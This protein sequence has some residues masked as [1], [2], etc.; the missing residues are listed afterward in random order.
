MRVSLMHPLSLLFCTDTHNRNYLQFI[1]VTAI[2]FGLTAL[3]YLTAAV[4]V[5]QAAAE[6]EKDTKRL[7]PGL[8][9]EYEAKLEEGETMVNR[10][11]LLQELGNI[12]QP[13][14]VKDYEVEA[15]KKFGPDDSQG[16]EERSQLTTND[17]KMEDR[18][19]DVE[20]IE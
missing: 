3:A 11:D 13:I 1:V 9:E 10:P 18:V 15:D 7:R 20:V 4:I 5:P 16:K 6:L 2:V 14:I 8:W 17:E 19:V 12:M